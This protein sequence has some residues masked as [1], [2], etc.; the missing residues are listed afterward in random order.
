LNDCTLI[1]PFIQD[2]EQGLVLMG[3]DAGCAY[4]K[5]HLGSLWENHKNLVLDNT[6]L[7]YTN[8][9][10]FFGGRLQHSLT[11]G[12][13]LDDVNANQILAVGLNSEGGPNNNRWYGTSLEGPQVGYYRT[14]M[15][16]SHN[17]FNHCRWE[18]PSNAA[19]RI[20][21]RTT[22]VS[23]VLW[24]GYGLVN[25]V[26]TFDTFGTVS[27]SE[28]FDSAGMYLNNTVATNGQVIPNNVDTT[29]TGWPTTP[30]ARGITY[31]SATGEFTPRPGR[32]RIYATISFAPN[33]TGRRFAKIMNGSTLLKLNEKKP[34][35]TVRNTQELTAS[36]RFNGSETFKIVVNQ[37]SGADLALDS[38]SG[39]VTVGAD[40]LGG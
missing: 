37:T 7:G 13:T 38:S 33:A 26:E 32:W 5:I 39:Y 14:D 30:V 19:I 9:N 1:V 34:D 12:A 23:N 3:N 10:T 16:G 31:D 27:P 35:G 6:A 29:L 2:F 11:K 40:Y 22:A 18:S 36:K 15:S 24:K 17:E 28:R 8:E 21:W 4:N 20:R 25:V